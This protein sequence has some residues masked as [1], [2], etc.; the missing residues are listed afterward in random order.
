M[1]TLTY[2]RTNAGQPDLVDEGFSANDNKAFEGLIAYAGAI[3][4]NVGA[5]VQGTYSS[6]ERKFSWEMAD[7]RYANTGTLFGQNFIYGVTL[8][9][10]PT[11]QDVW[12]STPA[13]NFPFA[14]SGFAPA[15]AAQTML[16]GRFM[17][18]VAGLGAYAWINDLVYAEVSGYNSLSLSTLTSLGV[19]ADMAM[20]SG[21]ISDVAPYWR[22]AAEP[23]WGNHSLQ[24][25][26]FGMAANVFPQR[27]VGFGTDRIT[28]IGFDSQYQY[29]AGAFSITTRVTYI[30]EV[31]NLAA[32]QALGMASNRSNSLNSFRASGTFVWGESQRIAI[33]GAYFNTYGSMDPMLYAS[34]ANGS[35]DTR[36]WIAEIA[37][38]PYGMNSPQLWP[39]FNARIGLQ[40]TWYE[41][42]NGAS[43]NY[44][45]AGRNASDDNTLLLYLRFLM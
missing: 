3:T 32:S 16:D 20:M 27:M 28:D 1:G 40:Y 33:T 15:P 17:F 29:I 42:F 7:I 37:Y 41:K 9:N 11:L 38:I 39:W 18:Q 19:D 14:T 22:F 4:P 5:Y 26:T 2:T 35:P 6:A 24:I 23:T 8:H 34:S 21:A 25:G 13:T 44:D 31:Q 36:G 43:T 12:N 45:G 30:R 10:S